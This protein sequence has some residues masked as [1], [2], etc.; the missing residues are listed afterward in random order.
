M[1]GSWM[2]QFKCSNWSKALPLIQH[3]K[4]RKFHRG[5]G[6]S[7]FNAVFGKEAYNGLE[8]SNLPADNKKKIKT[9]NDLFNTFTAEQ[10]SKLNDLYVEEEELEEK[11]VVLTKMHKNLKKLV[12]KTADKYDEID[13]N[14][15]I[16]EIDDDLLLENEENDIELLETNVRVKNIEH[17][18]TKALDKLKDQAQSMLN[19][20]K[21]AINALNVDDI[22]LY[23]ADDVDLGASDAPNIVC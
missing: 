13:D 12:N 17:V 16:D 6:T 19:R 3:Q 20:N 10:Q 15:S 2:R 9:I 4:N 7:P 5:I 14:E 21:K 8:I 18:R 11:E 23:K 22:V 1:L